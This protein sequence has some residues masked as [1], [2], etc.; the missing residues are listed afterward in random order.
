[1]GI[2]VI[3]ID[4]PGGSGKSTVASLL[5]RRLR[6]RHLDSGAVYRALTAWAMAME[7]GAFSEPALVS[8]LQK[9]HLELLDG[10]RVT[11]EGRDLSAAIR[12]PVVTSEVWRVAD[13]AG[14]R[15]AVNAYLRRL[16]SERPAVAEG[17]DMGRAF[18]AAVLKVF[19][20]AH[21]EERARRRGDQ[22]TGESPQALAERVERDRRRPVGGLQAEPDAF[23]I[24]CTSIPPEEVVGLI[25]AEAA[26]RGVPH[27][28]A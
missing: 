19:L 21:P 2:M 27:G 8:L 25:L 18:P 22:G 3:A 28:Q 7:G 15:A 10:G 5:A 24:D 9:G 14:V 6:W 1:M 11:V 26:K 23:H 16:V 4:G 17:R 12:T 20:D 13:M